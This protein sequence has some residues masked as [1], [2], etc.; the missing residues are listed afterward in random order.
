MR[1]YLFMLI[2]FISLSMSAQGTYE[3]VSN[4]EYKGKMEYYITKSG[5]T[6]SVGQ[7]ITL[8]VPKNENYTTI[9]R[10]GIGLASATDAMTEVDIKSI[11]AYGRKTQIVL[12]RGYFTTNIEAS[13]LLEEVIISN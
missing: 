7:S 10:T 12:Q 8:G 9:S 4:K 11:K 2:M 13:I 5:D 3:S 6:L 1:K